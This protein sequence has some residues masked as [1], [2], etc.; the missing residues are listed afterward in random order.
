MVCIMVDNLIS[1]G[2]NQGW[3][4][5]KISLA[6][7]DRSPCT[8]QSSFISSPLSRA[9]EGDGPKICGFHAFLRQICGFL[10]PENAWVSGGRSKSANF[11]GEDLGPNPSTAG[12]FRKKFGKIPERPRNALRAFPGIPLESAAVTPKP[13]NSRHLRLP[14]HFQN[15][16]PLSTAGD[17]SFFRRGSGEAFQSWSWDS[18]QY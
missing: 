12:T 4:P 1:C 3:R 6:T 14:E 15:S 13:Y 7:T 10:R 17:A 2:H 9:A 5:C 11:R 16:L 18:Q 8:K